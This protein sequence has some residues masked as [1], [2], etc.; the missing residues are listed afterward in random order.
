MKRGIRLREPDGSE[1][2]I[3]VAPDSVEFYMGAKTIRSFSMVPGNVLRLTWFLLWHYF[4][5]ATLFG[6]RA[7]LTRRALVAGLKTQ[8]TRHRATTSAVAPAGA[9]REA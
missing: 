6:T 5:V 2:A 8:A 3:A 7:H 1:F 9:K 4:V